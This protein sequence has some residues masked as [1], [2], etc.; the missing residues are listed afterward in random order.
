MLFVLWFI[1]LRV[2]M[3]RNGYKWRNRLELR[4]S[5][6]LKSYIGQEMDYNQISKQLQSNK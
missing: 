3:N 2:K 6:K 4:W 5:R 1:L